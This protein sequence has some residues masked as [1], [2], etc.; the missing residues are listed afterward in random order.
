MNRKA[1]RLFA[2]MGALMMWILL[3]PAAQAVLLDPPVVNTPAS[4]TINVA[5]QPITFSGTV[6]RPGGPGPF[7]EQVRVGKPPDP[8]LDPDPA[9]ACVIA[10]GESTQ[11]Q[12][13]GS[14]TCTATVLP[15]GTYNMNVTWTNGVDDAGVTPIVLNIV[16]PPTPPSPTTSPPAAVPAPIAAAFVPLPPV[17]P[18]TEPTEEP[19]AEAPVAVVEPQVLIPG[20]PDA[21]ADVEDVLEAWNPN[22]HPKK[23]LGVGVAAF[24]ILTLLGPGGLALSS[25]AG[26]GMMG[27]AGAA[28]GAAAAAGGV[29]GARKSGS[30]K[31]AKVKMNK[32]S[33]AGAGVGDKSRTWQLPG[34]QRVDAWSMAVPICWQPGRR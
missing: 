23:V 3:A 29:G 1:V 28:A 22:D 15:V 10:P 13:D 32:F 14:W 21:P 19:V 16:D 7:F 9:P 18:T 12:P 26:A 27:A 20:L 30:V 11:V 5:D 2:V 6:V 4:F 8:P 33:G 17:E 34:W 25:V 24:T 31:A